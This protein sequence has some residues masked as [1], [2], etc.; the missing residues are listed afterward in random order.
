M[1]RSMI[2]LGWLIRLMRLTETPSV[3]MT[4]QITAQKNVFSQLLLLSEHYIRID[5]PSVLGA[6]DG[7]TIKIDKMLTIYNE[8]A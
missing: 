6:L 1:T 4:E 3:M 5:G 7:L 2:L 8:L